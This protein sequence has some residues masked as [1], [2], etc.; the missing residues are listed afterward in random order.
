MNDMDCN[1]WTVPALCK[2]PARTTTL[3]LT[4]RPT[5]PPVT[6]CPVVTCPTAKPCPTVTPCPTTPLTLPPTT[7]AFTTLIPTTLAPT[8]LVPTTLPPTTPAP[9]TLVP[10]TLPPTTESPRTPTTECQLVGYEYKGEE[11]EEKSKARNAK[12]CA[13]RY[14]T[15]KNHL[16]YNDLSFILNITFN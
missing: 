12:A 10:T 9:T 4:P 5:C 15:F 3:R 6:Q 16:I 1:E 14:N 13:K 11:I 2:I 8:T 7:P